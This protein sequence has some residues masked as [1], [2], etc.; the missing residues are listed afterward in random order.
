MSG[1]ISI[2][3][4]RLNESIRIFG[5]IRD[6]DEIDTALSSLINAKPV[7][8]SGS[9]AELVKAYENELSS[10]VSALHTLFEQTVLI[11]ENAESYLEL[12]NTELIWTYEQIG[13]GGGS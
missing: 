6:S 8:S 4:N 10:M 3:I 13:E 7:E 5:S 9:T 1:S 12:T 2:N 11:L